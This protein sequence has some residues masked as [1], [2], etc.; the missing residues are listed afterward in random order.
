[1]NSIPVWVSGDGISRYEQKLRRLN[2]GLGKMALSIEEA[3]YVDYVSDT[4][5]GLDQTQK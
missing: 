5:A 1:M 3:V 4:Y 2:N